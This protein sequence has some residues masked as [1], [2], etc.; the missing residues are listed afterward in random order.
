MWLQKLEQLGWCDRS[1]FLCVLLSHTSFKLLCV[2]ERWEINIV[3]RQIEKG[4]EFWQSETTI[5]ILTCFYGRYCEKGYKEL[6]NK[7]LCPS[8]ENKAQ[9]Q[10][11]ALL[12]KAD[13]SFIN[14]FRDSRIPHQRCHTPLCITIFSSLRFLEARSTTFSSIVLAHTSLYIITG[15]VCPILCARSCACKSHCGFYNYKL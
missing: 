15:F 6:K 14:Q 12:T 13:K 4:G 8:L 7:T 10:K 1:T 11:I 9:T 5:S 3:S 2:S